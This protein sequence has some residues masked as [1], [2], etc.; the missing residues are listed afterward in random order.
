MSIWDLRDKKNWPPQSREEHSSKEPRPRAV[1]AGAKARL[2]KRGIRRKGGVRAV[3]G[4]MKSSVQK[5]GRKSLSG[6]RKTEDGTGT[7]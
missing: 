2:G 3:R 1:S 5:P 4:W 7:T 6:D